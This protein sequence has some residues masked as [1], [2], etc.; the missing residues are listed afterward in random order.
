MKD[1]VFPGDRR[2]WIVGSVVLAVI[3]TGVLIQL[4]QPRQVLLGSNGVAPR[5]NSPEVLSDSQVCVKRVRVPSQ[6]TKV[7]WSIDT[8]QAGKPRM[9]VEVRLW[10]TSQRRGRTEVIKG[11]RAAAPD[12]TGLGYVDLPLDRPVPDAPHGERVADICVTPHGGGIFL[13]GNALSGIADLPL[14]VDGKVGPM[15]S[16]RPMLQYL[17][18]GGDQAMLTRLGSIFERMSLFRPAF[19]GPW[20]YWLIFLLVVPAIAYGGLRAIAAAEGRSR[21]RS[22]LAVYGLTLATA[23]TWALV[24]PS[25]QTPDETEHIGAVQ[26]FAETGRAVDAAPNKA[27]PLPWASEEVYAIDAAHILP[28]IESNAAKLPWPAGIERAWQ[29]RQLSDP[30]KVNGGGFHPATRAHSPVYY[31][32]MSPAY[33]A[34]R[35]HSPFTQLLAVRWLSAALSSLIALFAF[36]ALLELMPRR[37]LFAVAGGLMVGFQ[38]MAGFMAAAV[39]ND[40]GVNTAGAALTWLCIRGLRRGLTWK[41]GLAIGAVT[42]LA[43]ILKGTGY[44][45]WPPVLLA[46]AG[47]LWRGR[48]E[49]RATAAGAVAAVA[50]VVGV[51][52]AWGAI[53]GQFDRSVATTPG[54]GSPTGVA[55]LH[56]LGTYAQWMWQFLIP[57]R[58]GFMDD[59]TWV[60]WPFYNVYVQRGFA[61]FGWYAI[62]FQHWVYLTIVAVGAA[63]LVAGAW[64]LWQRRDLLKKYF[65]EIVFLATVPLAVVFAVE[66]VYVNVSGVPYDGTPEQGRYGFPALAACAVIAACCARAFGDRW[67]PRVAAALVAALLGLTIAGQWRMIESFYV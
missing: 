55:G 9:A 41:L 50:G 21:R 29:E 8:R 60:H 59:L 14:T 52:A 33:L 4:L 30:S 46:V 62:E 61:S 3:L 34:V 19:V 67:G 56:D 43:P 10:E 24:T 45:L 27:R 18:D 49:L 7:R 2:V 44:E 16:F 47:M 11:T 64:F 42:A 5:N 23:M 65:W 1:R 22:A 35:D 36:L 38:P 32:L 20:T 28:S 57:Y 51:S 13:W 40:A 6:A 39:N 54:G 31:A 53:S 25:F 15:P 58:P 48:K 26:Y 17:G 66:A 63:L 37:P 12:E